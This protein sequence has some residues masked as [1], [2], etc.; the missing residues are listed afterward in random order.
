MIFHVFDRNQNA[1][2]E[3]RAAAAAGMASSRIFK[4]NKFMNVF[5]VVAKSDKIHL[6]SIDSIYIWC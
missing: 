3:R 5:L 4:N 6:K 1:E 2:S